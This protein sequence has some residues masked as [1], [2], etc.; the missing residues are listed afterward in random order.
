[1]RAPFFNAYLSVRRYML[2]KDG[3]KGKVC[4]RTEFDGKVIDRYNKTR[5]MEMNTNASARTGMNFG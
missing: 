3:I 4:G 1:M 2:L 5:E